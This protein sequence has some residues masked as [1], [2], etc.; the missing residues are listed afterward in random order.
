MFVFY[1]GKIY[2]K[3]VALQLATDGQID[4]GFHFVHGGGGGGGLKNLSARC[5]K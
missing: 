4:K 5:G 3:E 1:I 2:S